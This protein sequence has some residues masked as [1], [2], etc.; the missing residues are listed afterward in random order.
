MSLFNHFDIYAYSPP[1]ASYTEGSTLGVI[2]AG[3]RVGLINFAVG[4][5]SSGI[6]GVRGCGFVLADIFL[7]GGRL[8]GMSKYRQLSPEHVG[9]LEL[10]GV[11]GTLE[12]PSNALKDCPPGLSYVGPS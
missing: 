4:S 11:L 5:P 3:D 2:C 10:I 12:P 1:I 7:G 6:P 9:V 8:G